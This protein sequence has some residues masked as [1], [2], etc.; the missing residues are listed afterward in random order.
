MHLIEQAP[1]FDLI[2]ENR[3]NNVV[4]DV[5]SWIIY[6]DHSARLRPVLYFVKLATSVGDVS[7]HNAVIHGVLP[8]PS[9]ERAS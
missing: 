8:L 3:N 2:V 6:L 5:H 9:E 1:S 7:F 4:L